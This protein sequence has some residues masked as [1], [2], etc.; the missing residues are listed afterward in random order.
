[1]A[2]G[3][4][5]ARAGT[6]R[7]LCPWL[8]GRIARGLPG[9]AAWRAAAVT[10]EDRRGPCAGGLA[11]RGAAF[12]ITGGSFVAAGPDVNPGLVG[13]RRIWRARST[14][15]TPSLPAG[16]SPRSTDRCAGDRRDRRGSGARSVGQPDPCVDTARGGADT[17]AGTHAAAHLQDRG[18]GGPRSRGDRPCRDPH[19]RVPL[20]RRRPRRAPACAPRPAAALP[21]RRRSG[22]RTVRALPDEVALRVASGS[23]RH[24]PRRERPRL[25]ASGARL[26]AGLVGPVWLLLL[27]QDRDPALLG[28]ADLPA[29]RHRGSPSAT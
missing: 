20:Q 29:R 3:K 24:R 1:M 6:L 8:V 14:R 10:D 26:R 21:P 2:G 16:S 17:A 27:R 4:A 19:L 5:L 25:R 28:A 18:D 9:H 11:A 22:L 23:R 12:L 7:P 15:C 13:N